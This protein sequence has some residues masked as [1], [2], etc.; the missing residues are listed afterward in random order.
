MPYH[1]PVRAFTLIELLVVIAIVAVLVGILLP[2]LAGARDAGRG[3]ACLSNHRQ[4]AAATWLYANDFDGR[5]PA[6]GVPWGVEPFWAL[7]VQAYAGREGTGASDMYDNASIL[8]CP[9]V[10]ASS[11][12]RMTRTYAV[13]VAGHA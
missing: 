1:H 4:M 6:L 2:A 8:V 3:A 11:G 5:S 13:N 9:T 7:S 12:E 10:D